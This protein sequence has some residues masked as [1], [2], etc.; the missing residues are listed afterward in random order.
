V[1]GE[2]VEEVRAHILVADTHVHV[3][4]VLGKALH[5]LNHGNESGIL[6]GFLARNHVVEEGCTA[7]E[8]W[9]HAAKHGLK[10]PAVLCPVAKGDVPGFLGCF[11]VADHLVP[12]LGNR[13]AEF[14]VDVLVIEHEYSLA[15]CRTSIDLAVGG[16]GG[17]QQ[18]GG[19]VVLQFGHPCF[20]GFEEAGVCKGR[21]PAVGTALEDIGSGSTGQRCCQ[22]GVVLGVLVGRLHDLDRGVGCFKEGDL[23]GVE[24]Y[25]LRSPGP[26][27]QNGLR[28]L[29]GC[30][31]LHA[32]T[33]EQACSHEDQQNADKCVF[34]HDKSPFCVMSYHR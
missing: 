2:L 34:F 19:G 16:A 11:E 21:K 26:E 8:A 6:E 32:C 10:A 5:L 30:L 22:N 31:F 12:G 13:K 24:V 25:V 14:L 27:L 3:R 17:S 9:S 23:L 20:K 1:R 18:G 29:W 28:R 33:K 7:V 15:Y 4:H